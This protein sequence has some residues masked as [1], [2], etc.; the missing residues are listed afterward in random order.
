VAQV[1]LILPGDGESPFVAGTSFDISSIGYAEAEYSF[2]GLAHAYARGGSDVAAVDC[3]EFNTR[4]LVYRPIDD[5]AFNGT[6]WI[7]WLNVSGGIDAAPGWIF[8]HTELA[9]SG[10]AWV[11]V[12][13]QQMGV[14]GGTSILGFPGPG[15]VSIDPKRYGALHHPG[16][17]FSY[18]IFSQVSD[19]VRRAS[20]TILEGLTIEHAIATGESQSASRL[21][22]FVNEIDPLVQ[23]H[24]GFLIHARGKG[25]APL[26][27]DLESQGALDRDPVLFRDDLRVPVLCVESESDLI[28]LGYREA[29][30][31]NTASLVAW[32]MAGTSHADVYTFVAGPMDT[33]RL[34]IEEL[35]ANW[36]PVRE[37]F[38]METDRLVNAG[39]QHYV[40]NAAVRHLGLWVHHGTRP[41]QAPRIEMRGGSFITDH[42][43]NVKEGIRTPHVDVPTAVLSGTGNWGHPIG[44]LSGCTIPFDSEK[45]GELYPSRA[46]YFA[47]FDAA[48]ES[49]VA[50]G[51]ILIEDADEIK[52]IAEIN[53]PL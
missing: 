8:T 38:G 35:A 31:A 43:G 33:G 13:A 9:R 47:R 23:V 10:A 14:E 16:D 3:A 52:M 11:G 4:L 42:L 45:L 36:V 29:R 7:E 17:R 27:D 30:Q 1:E 5:A 28:T 15:L 40:M 49:A 19:A 46:I 20:G 26:D 44:F 12:S 51:F 39:P 22:T 24:D 25:A 53:S 21:T 50:A 18:D 41:P 48:L 6:V 34:P 32:E 37:I 2:A